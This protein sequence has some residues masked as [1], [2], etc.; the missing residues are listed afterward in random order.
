LFCHLQRKLFVSGLS[1][2]LTEGEVDVRRAELERAFRKYG[3]ARGVTCIVPTNTTFAFV[4][5]ENERMA[6]LALSEQ[7]GNYRLNRA[8]RSRHE[9]LQE[10]RAETEAANQTAGK[11]IKD[12]G[13]W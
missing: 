4:E 5:M 10:E 1:K 13:G 6:D 12:S 9:A 11:N 2:I 8:R 3:G 7:G